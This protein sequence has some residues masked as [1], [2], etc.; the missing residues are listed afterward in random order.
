MPTRVARSP[1]TVTLRGFLS[2]AGQG[3]NTRVR[4]IVRQGGAREP[5]EGYAVLTRHRHHHMLC[6]SVPRST[7]CRVGLNRE[8]GAK[9]ELP[10]SGERKRTVS[11]ALGHCA[12]EAKPSRWAKARVRKSEDLPARRAAARSQVVRHRRAT[13]HELPGAG[14]RFRG[15][16]CCKVP[17]LV[18]G[19]STHPR[20]HEPTPCAREQERSPCAVRLG[21]RGCPHATDGSD[22]LPQR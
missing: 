4:A 13:L 2:D 17:T 9:P 8:S 15:E 18:A 21:R 12:R 6:R 14:D 19:R 7:T 5:H 22:R 20:K 1:A 11:T 16:A 10:R 3:R